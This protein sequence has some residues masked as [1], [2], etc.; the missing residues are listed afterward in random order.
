MLK[1]TLERAGY[2]VRT[3]PDGQAALASVLAEPPDAMI[4]DIQM[5]RLNGREL[6]KMLHELMPDRLFPVMVMTSMTAREEREWVREMPGIEFLE[7]PLS[8]RQLVA[9]LN[10]H[11]GNES[12]NGGVTSDV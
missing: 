10:R 11:F 4:T 12:T 7:K 3:E 6:M 1:L 8:P 2:A 9:R 5:P